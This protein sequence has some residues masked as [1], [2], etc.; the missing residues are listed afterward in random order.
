MSKDKYIKESDLFKAMEKNS[1]MVEV[2]G[3]KKKNDR[4]NIINL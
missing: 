4:R 1:H 3:K 2:F